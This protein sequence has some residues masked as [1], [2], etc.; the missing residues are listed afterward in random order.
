MKKFLALIAIALV[1][2]AAVWV[3]LRIQIANQLAKVPEL[4]PESTLLLAQA[5]SPMRTRERWHQSDLYQIWREPSVQAWLQRPLAQLPK[6]QSSHQTLEEFLQLG[7]NHLFL[8]LTSLEKNEPVVIGGFH[9][10]T[11]EEK[12]RQFI[13]QREANW[14]PKSSGA[15]H[16]T[17]V[18]EQHPIE[19]VA[20]GNLTYTSVYHNHWFF[21][22]NDLATLKALLDRTRR[23]GEQTSGSLEENPHFAAATKHLGSDYDALLYVDPQPFAQKLSLLLAMAEQ[24]LATAELE[25]LKSVRSF[26]TT[27]GFQHGKM[28][29][30]DFL[31]MPRAESKEKL[32]QPLLKAATTDTFLYAV[33]E[34]HWPPNFLA[35]STG[36]AQ[37]LMA[38]LRDFGQTLNSHGITADEVR[39]TFG[40][41]AETSGIWT[42]DAH[43]PAFLAALPVKDPSRARKIADALA[44]MEVAG[45]GWTRTEENGSTF[46]SAQILDGLLPLSLTMA[47]N[48]RLF[49]LGL[50]QGAVKA[51]LTGAIPP[52]GLEKNKTFRDA[53]ALVPRGES[54]FN[55]VDTKLLYERLDPA[56]RPLLTMGATLYP[57]LSK[58]VDLA[59]FP[60][61]EAITR[62]LSP[63]VMSQR[64]END[65]YVTESIGPV[66]FRQA[67]AG[68]AAAIIGSLEYFHQ[69]LKVPG[70]SASPATSPP[71]TV[72]SPSPTPSPF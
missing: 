63:I 31:E 64:Y 41:Q 32:T 20:V 12:A 18:Y 42:Q 67:T 25:R 60:P 11:T 62:H 24:P 6:D 48:D 61:P 47:L 71:S 28:R 4:L 21:A 15:K 3:T 16:T 56:I 52:N 40:E 27:F 70:L 54:A 72:A 7:S 51:A 5:S 33:S 9:F 37:G 38:W 23:R 1:V 17:V 59:K 49:V 43:W 44:T 26:A 45:A 2:A 58:T 13:A 66:T 14:W 69:G 65:G 29:E 46:Y 19:V 10:E 22:S 36:P 68:I 30:V 55:Y 57:A 8:A 39:A 53:D 34:L 50:D 35:P